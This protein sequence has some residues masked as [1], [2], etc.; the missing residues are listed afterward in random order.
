MNHGGPNLSREFV[1]VLGVAVRTVKVRPDFV[2]EFAFRCHWNSF[3]N[4]DTAAGDLLG[5]HK[6]FVP[7]GTYC[8]LVRKIGRG[9]NCRALVEVQPGPGGRHWSWVDWCDL[10][11]LTLKEIEEAGP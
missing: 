7:V 1:G 5:G 10:R 8:A 3:E 4:R 11:P 9:T 6:W 2:P